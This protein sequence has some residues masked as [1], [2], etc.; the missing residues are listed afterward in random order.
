MSSAAL[1]SCLGVSGWGP[2]HW[3]LERDGEP[4]LVLA[5]LRLAWRL[6]SADGAE[7]PRA[8]LLLAS[9]LRTSTDLTPLASETLRRQR[10]SLAFR[11]RLVCRP[12]EVS[13]HLRS[14]QCHPAALLWCCCGPE[15]RLDVT[16]LSELACD[17]AL[18]GS[19]T[20]RLATCTGRR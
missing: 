2:L 13:L 15:R 17:D 3:W 11:H 14:W 5:R 4:E 20:C 16:L 10:A 18:P 19:G 12:G 7:A 8:S 1:L 6:A 9:L